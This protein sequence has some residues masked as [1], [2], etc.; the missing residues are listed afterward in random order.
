MLSNFVFTLYELL[1]YLLPGAV[2]LVGFSVVE[3]ALF[4]PAVPLRIGADQANMVTGTCVVLGSYILGHAVQAIGNLFWSG[5]EAAVLDVKKGNAPPWMKENAQRAALDLLN[6]DSHQLEPRWIF[7][8][9]DEYMCRTGET[10]DRDMFVYREG[11]YRGTAIALLLISVALAVRMCIP[12]CSIQ[13]NKD[14]F[15][16]SRWEIVFNLLISAGIAVLFVRRYR[17]FAEYRVTHAVMAGLIEHNN[18]SDPNVTN[19][20]KSVSVP[21]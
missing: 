1:G 20:R 2:A 6:T 8:A 21:E 9:L 3:W 18:A 16:V 14:V 7:R 19:K 11:F 13:L 4:F 5:A 12:G 17:R 15:C 10:G